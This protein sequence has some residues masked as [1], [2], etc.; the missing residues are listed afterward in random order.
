MSSNSTFPASS[1]ISDPKT[2]GEMS[3]QINNMSNYNSDEE[4]EPK[5]PK[6]TRTRRSSS[7]AHAS[8]PSVPKPIPSPKITATLKATSV[9][10]KRAKEAAEKGKLMHKIKRY[11]RLGV[12][13][14]L[15]P[16]KEEKE[17]TID[18]INKYN[19]DELKALL[20]SIQQRMRKKDSDIGGIEPFYEAFV[21]GGEQIAVGLGYRELTGVSD[22]LIYNSKV[23]Q[24][25]D[26][27]LEELDIEY[28][29]DTFKN[30]LFRL[31]MNLALFV[32]GY[33]KQMQDMSAHPEKFAKTKQ[34]EN[35][36]DESSFQ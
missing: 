32:R 15:I 17:F 14:G 26:P 29:L 30:P 2:L 21:Y 16:E 5:E 6:Q 33:Q 25:I 31:G 24:H 19:L 3:H 28:G 7:P 11:M 35:K 9:D 12:K 1:N 27:D 4:T 18:L 34:Q 8:Q 23:R 22:H 13:R 36:S 20:E 10:Q